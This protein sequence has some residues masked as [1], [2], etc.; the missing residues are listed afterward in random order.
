MKIPTLIEGWNELID[1]L[2]AGEISYEGAVLKHSKL[3]SLHQEEPQLGHFIRCDKDNKPL[4]EPKELALDISQSDSAIEYNVDKQEF[5]GAQFKEAQSRVRWV[6]WKWEDED[7]N[8]IISPCGGW[9]IKETEILGFQYWNT[10]HSLGGEIKSYG[11]L[12]DS[13]IELH[14]TKE[15]EAE[16]KLNN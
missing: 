6:G 11:Q 7:H 5:L 10:S 16:F 1:N 3:V 9:A 14:S 2:G 8:C 4:E 12:I 15:Y 13:G